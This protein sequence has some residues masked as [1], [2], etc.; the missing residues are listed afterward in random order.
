MS[1]K[2]VTKKDEEGDV[3]MGQPTPVDQPPKETEKPDILEEFLKDIPDPKSQP[4][5]EAS[6]QEGF[7]PI[8]RAQSKETKGSP[9]KEVPIST[10]KPASQK[11]AAAEEQE[12]PLTPRAAK[13][14][15]I[16]ETEQLTIPVLLYSLFSSHFG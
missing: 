11:A 6:H 12:A 4:S 1:Q 15:K 9:S 14:Q 10:R 2:K 16:E 5:S 8:T 7:G 3:K 13:R